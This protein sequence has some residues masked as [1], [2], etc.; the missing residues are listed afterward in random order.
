MKKLGLRIVGL[1]STTNKTMR[2][3]LLA[4][5]VAAMAGSLPAI[6][7]EDDN[8]AHVVPRGDS[9][10][11]RGSSSGELFF[12]VEEL[13]EEVRQLRGRLEETS[14][15]LERNSRQARER[16]VDLDERLVD[17]NSRLSE[18]EESREDSSGDDD[19]RDTSDDDK[20]ESGGSDS[21]DKDDKDNSESY[22]QPDE[23]ER[24][25]YASIQ[26]LIQEKENHDAA[27]DEIYTFLEEYPDGDLSV[28]AYYWLGELYLSKGA[29]EQAQQAFTIVTSRH[30]T[31]RKAP[32]AMFKLAV[33]HDRG[34]DSERAREIL[35]RL[36]DR[37]PDSNAAALGR[38][39]RDEMG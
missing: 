5:L 17:L 37:H 35:D 2:G 3:L 6:A 7:Q 15:Q 34:G 20:E 21:D 29:Y 16:Y 38:E 4:T 32:D 23:E 10:R 36:E 1:K 25:A 8:D 27:I 22:R 13:R 11:S 14:H 18:V 28:N 26:Y 12:M 39:Y 9:E 30:E 19:E 31:H 24:E 33:S